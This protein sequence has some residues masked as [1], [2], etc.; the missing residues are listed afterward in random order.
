MNIETIVSSRQDRELLKTII[1]PGDYSIVPYE[2][3]R[4]KIKVSDVK[5]TNEDGPCTIEPE[6]VVFSSDFDGTVIIGDTDFFLDKDIELILQQ[7]CCGE[8]C[9]ANMV[10]KDKNGE[11]VK[12][13]T[14][15][16]HLSEVTEE[17]LISDWSWNRLYESALHH[18]EKG[19]ALVREGRFPDAFRRFSKG[20][21]MIIAIEPIDEK[22]I[23]DDQVRELID[24]KVKL[25]NNLAFCQLK[26]DEFEAAKQLCDRALQHDP[27]NLKSRYRR[28]VAHT[29]LKMYEEAWED[30]QFV[31]AV[32]PDDVDAQARADHLSPIIDRIT[33]NYNNMVRRMFRM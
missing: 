33:S 30:I 27:D 3:S 18:K 29:G 32:N 12:E 15:Q 13:I 25:F 6:S 21:K 28:C 23:D 14:C 5:C 2:D 11:L 16:I 20:L 9:I 17:Q 8:T 26:F 31:L 1:T 22:V 7:M 19:V 24:V 10:Y 4:C